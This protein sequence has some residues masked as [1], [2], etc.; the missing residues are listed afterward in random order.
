MNENYEQL[1][2]DYLKGNL[3]QEGKNKVEELLASGEI[4]FIDFRAMEQL[5][6]ELDTVSTPEPSREMSQRFYAMLEEEKVA[7][8]SSFAGKMKEGIQALLSK[9]TMP[10]LAYMLLCC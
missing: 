7:A 4:D 6:D 10:R 3:D 9:I 8:K 1:I 5:Y 2:A